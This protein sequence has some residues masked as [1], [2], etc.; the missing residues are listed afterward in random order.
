MKQR[1]IRSVEDIED[2]FAA[3]NGRDW[4]RVFSHY[5]ADDCIWDSSERTLSGRNEL[6]KYWTESHQ[7][8]DEKLVQP[9]NVVFGDSSVYLHLSIDLKFIGSGS[10]LGKER[11][12]GDI[13]NLSCVDYYRFDDQRKIVFGSVFSKPV[14]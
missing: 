11:T 8:I 2:F 14:R 13:V 1:G 4:D 10:F 3:Y 5:M 7:A 6:I 9:K 12:A